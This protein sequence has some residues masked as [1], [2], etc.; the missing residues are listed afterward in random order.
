MVM[1]FDY[2]YIHQ[3]KDRNLHA[4]KEEGDDEVEEEGNFY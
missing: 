4:I 3:G 1:E 2:I